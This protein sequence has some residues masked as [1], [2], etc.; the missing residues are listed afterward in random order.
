MT[1][2]GNT[3]EAPKDW[4]PIKLSDREAYFQVRCTNET[5]YDN[6][7]AVM[8]A[9]KLNDMNGQDDGMMNGDEED[10]KNG[11]DDEDI[12]MELEGEVSWSDGEVEAKY[13]SRDSAKYL[14]A[15]SAT[16][17]VAVLF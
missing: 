10:M 8:K 3:T 11:R 2:C 12:H 15:A 4:V 9:S 6:I 7:E 17:L 14:A 13:D 1:R 16:M 5:D